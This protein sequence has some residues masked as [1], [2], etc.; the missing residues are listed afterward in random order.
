MQVYTFSMNVRIKVFGVT[1]FSK[2]ILINLAA[3][4]VLLF[5]IIKLMDSGTLEF[6]Q[7]T[8]NSLVYHNLP[9]VTQ[10]SK[11]I[12]IQGLVW[13]TFFMV[14]VIQ[15][16]GTSFSAIVPI[17]MLVIFIFIAR[18]VS[19]FGIALDIFYSFLYGWAVY[20]VS[21]GY[22]LLSLDSQRKKIR[23]NFEYYLD[24]KYIDQ[25]SDDP[26][27]LK[28]GGEAK[29]ITVLFSDIRSFSTISEK[30]SPEDLV[31][32]MNE[33]LTPM[34]N[35]IM[36]N[37]GIVD[38][39]IGDCIMAFWGAPLDDDLHAKNA[40]SLGLKM[41]QKLDELNR[42][43]Q[44]RGFAEV[45][46]G[47]GINT[48]QMIVGNMGSQKRFNYTV[49]GDGVNLASRLEGLTKYYHVP[50]IISEHTQDAVADDFCLRMLDRVAVKGKSNGVIIYQ[51]MGEKA[52]KDKYQQLI[53]QTQ[54]ALDAYFSQDWDRAVKEFKKME[55]MS[56]ESSLSEIFIQ[57]CEAFKKHSPGKDWD[58]VW[59]MQEK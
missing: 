55:T 5:L 16:V 21:V 25:I 4:L 51:V 52:D 41:L 43:W 42:Q 49:M 38:K 22:N 10:A 11:A 46:I 15:N 35:I 20:V 9:R 54:R 27:K 7:A 34:T 24:A 2:R 53:D 40:V 44:K 32:F 6:Y 18:I 48:D 58:G 30:L 47:I 36:S 45:K 57:R 39:Y 37:Q 1:L 3:S 14:V 19:G 56:D 59:Q 50:F 28:L 8:S 17:V 26:S 29:N 33:F 23:K 13:Q 31:T 12:T